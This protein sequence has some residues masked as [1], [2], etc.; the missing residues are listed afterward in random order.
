MKSNL[1]GP[2]F[3]EIH[4]LYKLYFKS[5]KILKTVKNTMYIFS[6]LKAA[7]VL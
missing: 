7:I 5:Y 6:E 1:K 4:R 2:K 3:V